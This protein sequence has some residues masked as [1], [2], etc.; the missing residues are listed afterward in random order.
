MR[1]GLFFGTFN[2]IHMGHLILANHIQQYSNLD[3]VWF[4]VTP[5][6]PFKKKEKLTDDYTRLDMVMRAI[7]KYPNLLASSIEFGLEQPNYTTKT[8]A[9]LREKY[10]SY[11]FSLIMG[12]DNLGNLHKWVN[13]EFL[14]KEYDIFVYPRN[15][16]DNRLPKVDMSRVHI[17]DNAPI[18]E[19]SS[20]F[21]RK[22]IGE[23]KNVR[24][25]L[26]PEVFNFIDG[27]NLYRV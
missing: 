22:A 18:V 3:Q 1:I 9:V 4:V 19:I 14:V 23:G 25:M 24:P 6:S 11:E 7:D 27:S 16:K 26:P 8:L 10:P 20:T 17:V 2:P 12:E 13:S 15:H 5:R 21:I